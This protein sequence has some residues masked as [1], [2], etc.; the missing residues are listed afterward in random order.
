MKTIETRG[1]RSWFGKIV[2]SFFLLWNALMALWLYSFLSRA[3]TNPSFQGMSANS[4]AAAVGAG[5][6]M[7]IL[8]WSLSSLVLGV[9]VVWTRGPRMIETIEEWRP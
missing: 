4:H 8:I 1:S 7:L 3:P 6:F 5:L 2:K 9:F